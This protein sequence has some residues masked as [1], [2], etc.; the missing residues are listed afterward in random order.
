METLK[1]VEDVAPLWG[2]SLRFVLLAEIRRRRTMSVAEMVAFLADTGYQVTGRPSKTISDALRWEIAR[3]RVVRLRRGVYRYGRAPRTTA[4]RVQL[5]AKRC[6]AWIV[7]VMRGEVPPPTPPTR[8][9]RLQRPYPL[10][11][12]HSRPPWADLGWLWTA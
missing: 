2:R 9:D 10:Y 11:H 7:A 8:Q 12:D 1:R 6:D 4:R 5:F 3:G